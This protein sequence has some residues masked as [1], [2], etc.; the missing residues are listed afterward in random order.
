M[1]PRKLLILAYYFPPCAAV[2]V[3]RMVGLVRHLP[4]FGWH[5]IVVAPPN[6]AHE[7]IDP[8]LLQSVPAETTTVVSVPL[9]EGYWG[10]VQRRFFPNCLWALRAE[11]AAATAIRE[12]QP[13][14][15]LTSG[16]PHFL[17]AI[18]RRLKHTFGLPWLADFRDPFFAVRREEGTSWWSDRCDARLERHIFRDADIVVG[19]TPLYTAGL[20]AAYPEHA[21][22]I[23]TITNGY[24]PETFAGATGPPPRERLEVLYA[25]ELYFGRDPRPFLEALQ[26]LEANPHADV[27]PVAFRFLGRWSP[28]YDLAGEVARRGLQHTVSV[29]GLVPYRE[30]LKSMTEA[31]V[32]LLMHTP[33]YAHGLP[34]KVFE[35]VGARRPVLVMSDHAG[36]IGQVLHEAGILHR[37]APLR[38]PARIAQALAELARELKR[39]TPVVAEAGGT[40][41]FTREAMAGRF[42]EQLD[43]MVPE[44]VKETP[45]RSL[46]PA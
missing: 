10:K 28:E 13:D 20:H 8:A 42:A 31:D 17:H 30:C 29:G 11:R 38:D 34:A 26:I 21:D 37:I 39:G 22:K 33:K 3:H 9:S 40:A 27:P 7:P 16:P 44:R 25:G 19:N 46:V 1:T 2:A 43:N 32:L 18:G 15:I 24:D 23:V 35:Y 14:A 4:Q 45:S 41:S 12:H 36:D 6:P 5:S